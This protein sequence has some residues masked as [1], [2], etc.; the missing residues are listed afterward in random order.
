M[1]KGHIIALDAMGGDQAPEMVIKGL[2]IAHERFPGIHFLLFGDSKRL[3]E[4][5]DEIP[6]LHRSC[7][8]HHTVDVVSAEA[9]P[10]HALRNGRESSMRIAINF[11]SF[12]VYKWTHSCYLCSYRILLDKI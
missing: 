1:S 8:V 10:S 7:S 5:L 6:A 11:N 4:L 2:E 12:L 3:N 9:R